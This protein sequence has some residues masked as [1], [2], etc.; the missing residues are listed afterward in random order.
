[1]ASSF[2]QI[3]FCECGR[4]AMLNSVICRTCYEDGL[5]RQW[6]EE[7]RRR[8]A[9]EQPQSVRCVA[10][11]QYRYARRRPNAAQ[12]ESLAGLIERGLELFAVHGGGVP[13][14]PTPPGPP[15][16]KGGEPLFAEVPV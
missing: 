15:F 2:R 3:V 4:P 9:E 14:H 7:F 6:R 11:R 8:E 13:C 1:M 16:L 12:L 5:R 10:T